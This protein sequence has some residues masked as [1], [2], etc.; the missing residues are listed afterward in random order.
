MDGDEEESEWGGK[1]K[2]EGRRS[3]VEGK[4]ELCLEG[5]RGHTHSRVVGEGGSR[6]DG[7]EQYK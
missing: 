6:D 1:M 4:E 7:K 2:K 3:L 5:I